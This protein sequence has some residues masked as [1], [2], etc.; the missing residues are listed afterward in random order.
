M[1][2]F[3]RAAKATVEEPTEDE[4]NLPPVPAVDDQGRRSL[5]DHRDYVL[6]LIEP[7]TPFGMSLIDAWGLSLCEDIKG[8][9]DVPPVPIAEADG[10]AFRFADV[11]AAAPGTRPTLK[12]VDDWS[13]QEADDDLTRRL[14]ATAALHD[15]A[16]HEAEAIAVTAGQPLPAGAD[17]VAATWETAR[18]KTD[19]TIALMTKVAEGD[20]VRPI[21]ADA[22]DGELLMA[23]GT[24]LNDRRSALLAAAGFDRVL[25]RPRTRIALVQVVAS[26]GPVAG[27]AAGVGV[28]M[29]TAAAKT[30]GAT[31]WRVDADLDNLPIARE[32]LNDELIRADLVLTIGGLSEERADPRLVGLLASMG[33]VDVAKVALRPGGRHGCG[34]I[35]D[36]RTPVV[37]LPADPAALLIAYHAF[38]RPALRK[39]M[40][41]QPYDHEPML[42]FAE[43]AFEAELG[44]TQLVP[45]RLSQEGNRYLASEITARR[46]TML[47]TLVAADA[48]VVLPGEKQRFYADEPLAG[49]LLDD[50]RIDTE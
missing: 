8:D 13:V 12:V 38:A 5:K 37:M 11:A 27:G 2:L 3:N 18:G 44:V 7:L 1:G 24:P 21:A 4:P 14:P 48:L 35:G 30:D 15:V 50:L 9:G 25:A 31:V 28:Q 29:V 49:W 42:C 36:E 46:H 17:T 47:S 34:L 23:A 26:D 6:G 19:G 40:G 33:D 32:R 16:G 43:R 10:Y 45:V 39:L 20:W 41:A 22:A